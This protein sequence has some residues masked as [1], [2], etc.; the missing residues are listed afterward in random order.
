MVATEA[1]LDARGLVK[2][3]GGKRVVDGVDLSCRPGEVLGLL[4]ANGA[5]AGQL[6][7]HWAMLPVALPLLFLT[8]LAFSTVGLLFTSIIPSMDHMGLPFFL[9]IMPIGFASSTYFPLPDLP[10]LSYVVQVN[11]LHHLA[12]GLRHL[13]IA[14]EVTWHLAAV[15]GLCLLMLAVFMPIDMRLLRRRVFGDG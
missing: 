15:A 12:E 5:A 6:Y 7:L 2:S 13:L 10:V 9:V 8:A 1:L 14:G 3:L 11:P 4:G